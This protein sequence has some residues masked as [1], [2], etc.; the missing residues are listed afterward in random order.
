LSSRLRVD[1]VLLPPLVLMVVAFGIAVSGNASLAQAGTYV[2]IYG[3]P[4]IGL[5]LLLG[6]VNQISIGQAGF[7]ALGA[8]AVAYLCGTRGWPFWP[9]ALAGTATAA[10]TGLGVGFIALRF[11]GHYL[12]MAT[13]AFGL[14]TIGLIHESPALGGASGIQS[15]PYAQLGKIVLSGTKAYWFA[16]C[17]A[18]V[19]AAA[20][21]NLLRGRTGRAFEAIRNDELAAEVIGVPT[22]R[23]KILA[24]TY[25]GALGGIGGSI[26]AAF[27]GLVVPEALGVSLSI[28]FLLMVVLG[29]T[30]SI[31][32]ALVGAALIGFF[33]ILGRQ[34]DNLREVAY[35]VLVVLIVAVAPGGIVGVVRRVLPSR[36]QRNVLAEP[37][38]P[39]QRTALRPPLAPSDRAAPVEVRALS[40]RF[41]GLVAVDAVSFTLQRGTLTALIG[42]NGAGKT[43]LFN[44]LSGVGGVSGG[45]VLIGGVDATNWQPH[46][47]AALGVGRSFQNARLFADMTVLENVA[48]GAFRVERSSF[49]ADLLGLRAARTAQRKLV[50]RARATLADL[51]LEHLADV[52]ARDLAFGERRR[53][54]LARAVAADPWLL[55][56]DEP[57]AGLNHHEREILLGD[58]RRLRDRGVTMLLIEHDMRLVMTISDRV[59][60]LEF[61]RIIADGTPEAV[62]S[63]PAVIEAYLGKAAS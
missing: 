29:G 26:Y 36:T 10:L 15:V 13:M 33:D 37:S 38:P 35:G 43:S 46:R 30:G 5:S 25:A 63:E 57:A 19:A 32:G 23:Y 21:L 12:A 9:A 61:G 59:M 62:R 52:P 18:I 42:P 50:D 51:G 53:V 47:V 39:P 55:L 11:R 20:T 56:V 6:N 3:I 49:A 54:E 34:Y 28:G 44:A 58:L 48:V 31:S 24:F 7:F 22:R 40:K 45:A 2:A 27:L 41:G 1:F 14:I 16:W 60:V 4:A 8:Y 17:V